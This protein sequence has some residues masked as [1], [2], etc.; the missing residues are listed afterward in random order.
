MKNKPLYIALVLGVFLPC[1]LLLIVSRQYAH[2][3]VNPTEEKQE[4]IELQVLMA[5]GAVC[6][7]A[8]EDYVLGVVLGEMPASFETEALKAQAVVTRTYTLRGKRHDNADICTDH[9]CCQAYCA[10]EA[11]AGGREALEKI[12]G[13]VR[14][15][16]GQVLTY[17]GE[18]IEATYFSCSGGR[19]EDAVAVWGQSVPYLQAV[20]SPGEEKAQ[21]Y[22]KTTSMTA[23]EFASFFGGLSGIPSSWIGEITYTKGGGV[24]TV[25]I[26]GSKYKGTEVRKKLGLRSTAFVIT[27]VGSSVTITTKGSGHRVGMSQ[28]GADAMAVAGSGYGEILSHYY[29]GTILV[30]ID[31]IDA[32]R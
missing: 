9:T 18:L 24:D 23:S 4:Q 17:Q 11:Y 22:L 28:Y 14:A 7:M 15:T 3:D 26:G 12:H 5:D 27:V 25:V 10:P 20:D 21:N 13:A 8:L 32:L 31:N 2:P 30:G 1:I 29:P 16:E 6:K 19:T